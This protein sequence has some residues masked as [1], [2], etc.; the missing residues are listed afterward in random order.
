[1]TRVPSELPEHHLVA[2]ELM[3]HAFPELPLPASVHA[4]PD[5]YVRL[6]VVHQRPFSG[7]LLQDSHDDVGS[8]HLGQLERYPP[9]HRV[10]HHL[11]QLIDAVLVIFVHDSLFVFNEYDIISEMH[12]NTFTVK[13]STIIANISSYYPSR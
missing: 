11:G 10:V 5:A 9:E 2:S 12:S 8:Q 1:M 4:F 6:I 13:F 7:E 3:S